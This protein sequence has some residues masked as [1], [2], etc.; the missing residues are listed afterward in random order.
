MI[1]KE[2]RLKDRRVIVDLNRPVARFPENPVLTAKD[3]N[4][5]WQDPGLQVTT[6]HNAASR[7]REKTPSCCSGLICVAA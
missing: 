5:V 1:S 4:Q 7:Y 6:V 2:V 3:V